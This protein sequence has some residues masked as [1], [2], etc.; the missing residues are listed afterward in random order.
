M[1]LKKYICIANIF[2]SQKLYLSLALYSLILKTCND[3]GGIFKSNKYVFFIW[4]TVCK[5]C[6]LYNH[7]VGQLLRG[8]LVFYSKF[9]STRLLERFAPIFYLSCEHVLYVYILKQNKKSP[10]ISWKNSWILKI[11]RKSNFVGGKFLKFWSS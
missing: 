7:M 8:Q 9:K 3:V 4:I 5:A 1:K 2:A 6:I 10:R 11:Y